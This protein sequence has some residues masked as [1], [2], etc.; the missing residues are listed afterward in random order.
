MAWTT[1]SNLE[2]VVFKEGFKSQL[3][4][5]VEDTEVCEGSKM[6]EMSEVS[7]ELDSLE[8]AR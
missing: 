5:E 3:G 1:V 8:C 6:T 2:R 4:L 7:R